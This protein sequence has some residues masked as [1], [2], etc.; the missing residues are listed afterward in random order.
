MSEDRSLCTVSKAGQSRGFPINPEQSK[1]YR[2]FCFLEESVGTEV[3]KRVWGYVKALIMI[4]NTHGRLSDQN[5]KKIF[6]RYPEL[7]GA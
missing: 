7:N 2:D 1:P 3:E 5:V 6:E 4:L